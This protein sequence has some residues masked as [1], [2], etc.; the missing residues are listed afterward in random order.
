MTIAAARASVTA[1][2][3]TGDR[4]VVAG[5]L[6]DSQGSAPL[7]PGAVMLIDERG[8]AE[9]T[10]TGGCVEAAILAEALDLLERDRTARVVTYGVSDELAGDVGLMCGGVVHILVHEIT[11][12]RAATEVA[13]AR[14]VLDERPVVIATLVDGEH[15]GA[16]LALIDG[17]V[18]GSLETGAM[19]DTAVV[20]D[21][22]GLL[23]SG[24]SALRHYGADGSTLGSD[25]RVFLRVHG[26]RPQMLLIG[27]IDF[28]AAIAPM[29][30]ELGYAVTICDARETFVRSPR[31]SRSAEVV[32]QWPDRL[33]A[34]RTLGPRDAVLVLTHDA[35]FDEPALVAAVNTDVGYIGAL[36]SRRTVADRNERL[37]RAGVTEDK[38][39]RIF[40]PCGLDL[41]ARG[42]EQTAVSILAEIIATRTRR[43]GGHLRDSPIPIHDQRNSLP[44]G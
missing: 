33:I 20:R 40:S 7:E 10:V 18:T 43:G 38:L 30:A 19:L 15:A 4:S 11:G 22:R 39:A 35:K 28:S 24:Q 16:K 34:T 37:R 8:N 3:L 5:L 9:G 41:G 42:P 14:A 17:A 26:P 13:A 1:A 44:V 2:W 12:G 32:L 6:I 27:A 36:G 29:A 23:D 25:L 31:F 21:A